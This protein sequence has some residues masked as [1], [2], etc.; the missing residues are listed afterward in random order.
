MQNRFFCYRR[1]LYELCVPLRT[2][3]KQ[4]GT[5]TLHLFALCW[6]SVKSISFYNT[7]EKKNIVNQW[8]KTIKWTADTDRD[9]QWHKQ[10]KRRGDYCYAVA[11]FFYWFAYL[12]RL[13]SLLCSDVTIEVTWKWGEAAPGDQN[14]PHSL[15]FRR[16]LSLI[17]PFIP[18]LPLTTAAPALR[19]SKALIILIWKLLSTPNN[20]FDVMENILNSPP[21]ACQLFTLVF[22]HAFHHSS[23]I[24]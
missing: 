15:S 2:S 1:R 17:L 16:Y 21:T 12:K 6:P 5:C 20:H 8:L 3:R 19:F 18:G 22:H 7:W 4:A 13:Y 24:D 9:V 14:V 11:I 10:R 23:S